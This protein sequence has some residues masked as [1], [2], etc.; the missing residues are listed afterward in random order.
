MRGSAAGSLDSLPVLVDRLAAQLLAGRAGE[1]TMLGELSTTRAI[2][3]YLQGKT[4]MRQGGMVRR[5]RTIR[6]RCAK[7]RPSRSPR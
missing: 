4:A 1:L 7:T 3:E 5:K 6:P 2:T